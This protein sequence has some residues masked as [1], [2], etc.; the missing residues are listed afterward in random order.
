MPTSSFSISKNRKI[1]VPTESINVD[2]NKI[3]PE[4]EA[5]EY[6]EDEIDEMDTSSR[7]NS[8]LNNNNEVALGVIP[9]NDLYKNQY[10]EQNS[11]TTK[12]LPITSIYDSIT[13]SS[14]ANNAKTGSFIYN[15]NNTELS[16]FTN[17]LDPEHIENE[18]S[19]LE[20][21]NGTK[22]D[23]GASQTSVSPEALQ[24][25]LVNNNP[26]IL[27]TQKQLDQGPQL[28]SKEKDYKKNEVSDNKKSETIPKRQTAKRGKTKPNAL[29]ENIWEIDSD[30]DSEAV[31][32]IVTST[33]TKSKSAS[34]NKSMRFNHKATLNKID[35]PKSSRVSNK[36]TGNAAKG[37]KK[38]EK[39]SGSKISSKLRQQ[40]LGLPSTKSTLKKPKTGNQ[41]LSAKNKSV[42]TSI[43]FQQANEKQKAT[44]DPIQEIS[45]D[46]DFEHTRKNNEIKKINENIT[47]PSLQ[48][49]GTP[50]SPLNNNND[51]S[52]MY[53]NPSSSPI[54]S[55]KRRKTMRHNSESLTTQKENDAND[56][57][58]DQ[59]INSE[60]KAPELSQEVKAAEKNQMIQSEVKIPNSHEDERKNGNSNSSKVKKNQQK[61][62]SKSGRKNASKNDKLDLDQKT[63]LQLRPSK[64][65]VKDII[66]TKKEA[67]TTATKSVKIVSQPRR[68]TRSMSSKSN[69][70]NESKP[71]ILNEHFSKDENSNTKFDAER[72][73]SKTEASTNQTA[74]SEKTG[75]SPVTERT[76]S[77]TSGPTKSSTTNH[78]SPLN[79]VDKFPLANSTNVNPLNSC[80]APEQ[81]FHQLDA[82]LSM[83][84]NPYNIESE[85]GFHNQIYQGLNLISLNLINRMKIVEFEINK[86]QECIRKNLELKIQE[87]S[88]YQEMQNKN[89]GNYVSEL[90]S[91]LSNSENDLLSWIN[92]NGKDL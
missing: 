92:N 3:F 74:M 43:S 14:T 26:S 64:D 73:D 81:F 28:V 68:I 85:A 46:S 75:T 8:S 13:R 27:E 20:D 59:K 57:L 1:S 84:T 70:D 78:T 69:Q 21:L 89:F 4:Q 24:N 58:Y 49:E 31:S 36:K 16:T 18:A 83:T 32:G 50:L 10:A 33:T 40:T 45:M 91:R 12:K 87:V 30:L 39:S 37:R 44:L 76:D 86:K 65:V 22:Y 34:K 35:E 38:M 29:P 62:K 7:I 19:R 48:V 2:V 11:S 47:A 71:S 67:T 79:T 41:D 54:V 56:I 55:Y 5:D 60:N 88:K 82:P 90:V 63:N 52:N 61:K 9:A 77:E 72:K 66:S 51:Y 53:Y 6:Y 42:Q 15:N 17:I 80:N 25:S 23:K